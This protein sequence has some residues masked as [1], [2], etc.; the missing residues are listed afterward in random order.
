M[1]TVPTQVA[2][3]CCVMNSGLYCHD[4][5]RGEAQSQSD[6]KQRVGSCFSYGS[7]LHKINVVPVLHMLNRQNNFGTTASQRDGKR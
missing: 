2:L 7:K 6:F 5:E 3:Y 4:A 1:C